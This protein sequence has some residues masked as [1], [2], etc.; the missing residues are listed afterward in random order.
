MEHSLSFRKSNTVNLDLKQETYSL[1][2]AISHPVACEKGEGGEEGGG[3]D[4]GSAAFTLLQP[5]LGFFTRD[6]FLFI[7]SSRGACSQATTQGRSLKLWNS[8][9]FSIE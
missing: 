8:R 5:L 6:Q 4:E 3:E 2:K 7:S 9:A 1:G